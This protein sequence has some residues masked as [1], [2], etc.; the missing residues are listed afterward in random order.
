[1]QLKFFPI[2]I[3]RAT[4]SEHVDWVPSTI[5]STKIVCTKIEKVARLRLHW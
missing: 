3:R 5:E 4:D 2:N 1:M